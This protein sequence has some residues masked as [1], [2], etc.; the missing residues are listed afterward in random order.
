M[1]FFIVFSLLFAGLQANFLEDIGQFFKPAHLSDKELATLGLSLFSAQW[2]EHGKAFSSDFPQANVV[3]K[4]IDQISAPL[5]F[6]SF[7]VCPQCNSHVADI[8]KA[9]KENEDIPRWL[10][11]I[12][13]PLTVCPAF[14]AVDA[15]LVPVCLIAGFGGA[16]FLTHAEPSTVCS[17]LPMCSRRK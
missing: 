1:L 8:Q 2:K 11:E 7:V 14:Y 12:A 13:L 16:V 9:I 6:A 3:T 17:A 4:F 5:Q 10:V 15:Q